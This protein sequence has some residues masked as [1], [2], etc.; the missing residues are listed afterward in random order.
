MF[1]FTTKLLP[2]S[3]IVLAAAVSAS[4]LTD[5]EP[6]QV[7]PP[8][9]IVAPET[10][11]VTGDDPIAALVRQH[12]PIDGGTVQSLVFERMDDDV[13]RIPIVIDG[14]V[15]EMVLARESLRSPD[16]QVLVPGR[17]GNLVPL[18]PLPEPTTYRGALANQ[19]DSVVAATIFEDQLTAYIVLDDGTWRY[20][21]PIREHVPMADVDQ[22]LVYRGMD[23]IPVP[24]V[25]GV[26]DD[27][28]AELRGP[29]AD[30][31]L[32]V[33]PPDFDWDSTVIAEGNANDGPEPI[34]GMILNDPTLVAYTVLVAFDADFPY[35]QANNSS[36][37]QTIAALET[38]MAGVNIV[39]ERDTFI[40]HNIGTIIV[41][42]SF[43]ADPY[44]TSNAEALLVQMRNHW[45]AN[46]TNIPRSVAHLFTGRN[47]SDD[48][49]GYAYV[50]VICDSISN[51]AGY[52]LSQVTYSTN[53]NNRIALVAHELGHNWNAE[54]C[55][56]SPHE[57]V[58]CR[59]M[60]SN[61][62]QCNGYGAPEFGPCS[63]YT[64]NAIAGSASCA[65]QLSHMRWVD[66]NYTGMTQIGTF[67]FPFKTLAGAVNAVPGGG[68]IAIK[69][70]NSGETIVINKAVN[71]HAWNGPVRI[72]QQ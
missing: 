64:I 49:I 6:E 30:E 12:M 27:P 9:M 39:Y 72:G 28:M 47:L 46:H 41:R 4:A 14:E 38:V 42:T 45:N 63:T 3:A 37:A 68:A 11:E 44:T 35:Y 66:F 43:L 2:C 62:N 58:V 32:L 1:D 7:E 36:V 60:C 53:A 70:G 26:P 22:H 24:G 13:V 19:F 10:I 40:R 31:Q 50:G 20:V 55:N 25:C 18:Q 51:G 57:C 61:I 65:P 8:R 52:G 16:F 29:Q 48:V 5:I 67:H 59:I 69:V 15:D 71:V 54:H 56:E 21:Q 23:T 34:G 17:N 33:I